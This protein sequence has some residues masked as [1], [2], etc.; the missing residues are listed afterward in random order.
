PTR[1]AFLANNLC[2][3]G[4]IRRK[5]RNGTQL[6]SPTLPLLTGQLEGSPVNVE[7]R[8][9]MDSGKDLRRHNF[10]CLHV[11]CLPAQNWQNLAMPPQIRDRIIVGHAARVPN[12]GAGL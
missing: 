10:P 11:Y 5:D 1:F 8:G 6:M 2:N 9:I 3:K 7:T 12:R 4:Q